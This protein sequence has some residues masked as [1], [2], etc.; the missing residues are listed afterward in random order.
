[1]SPLSDTLNRNFRTL[2]GASGEAFL[3]IP[4]HAQGRIM[5]AH[6]VKA[7]KHDKPADV[8][9]TIRN[10]ANRAHS[11]DPSLLLTSISD[12]LS[13]Y[14]QF[15]TACTGLEEGDAEEANSSFRIGFNTVVKL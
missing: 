12:L 4:D 1:M 10:Q 14:L 11:L 5:K 6:I 3:A 13:R 9:T 15:R 7:V 8:E 2:G